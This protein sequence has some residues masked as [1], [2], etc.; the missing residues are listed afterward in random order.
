MFTY[1]H[2]EFLRRG[3]DDSA[4]VVV[5]RRAITICPFALACRVDVTEDPCQHGKQERQGFPAASDRSH[6]HVATRK[7]DRDCR[8]LDGCRL[9]DA[10]RP[11]LSHKRTRDA[12]PL[13][14]SADCL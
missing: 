11:Q 8:G 12:K 2:R 13:E 1:L 10:L 3:H 7:H 9:S 14:A 6:A 4:N 5:V